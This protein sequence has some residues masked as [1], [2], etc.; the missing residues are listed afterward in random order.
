MRIGIR[1]FDNIVGDGELK[2]AVL[3]DPMHTKTI[4]TPNTTIDILRTFFSIG[5]STVVIFF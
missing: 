4:T 2:K 1:A 5:S 3:C